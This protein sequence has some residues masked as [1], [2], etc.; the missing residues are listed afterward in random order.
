MGKNRDLVVFALFAAALCGLA[1]LRGPDASCD[2]RNYHIYNAYAVLNHRFGYDLFPAQL[3]TFHAPIL[4]VLYESARIAFNAHP[5][6]LSALLALPHAVAAFLA[7]RITLLF[8][9]SSL[10]ARELLAFV[11]VV[12]G[13]SGA[14]GLPTL[15]S[16]ASEMV[17]G[18]YAL[19]AL[20]IVLKDLG[21][22]HG[23]RKTIS[24]GLLLG[25]AAGFKLTAVPY[26]IGVIAA[27]TLCS[28]RTFPERVTGTLIF[29]GAFLLGAA[30][31]AGPWWL[32]L[33]REYGNPLFPYFN[34]LFRSSLLHPVNISDGRFRPS[35]VLQALLYPFFWA[36]NPKTYVAELPIRDARFA[37]AYTTVAACALQQII[38]WRCARFASELGSRSP[39]SL[40]R[41]LKTEP[42][43]LDNFD[44]KSSCAEA[45]WLEAESPESLHRALN[46]A[47][48]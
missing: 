34:A 4:D 9:P 35:G 11:T 45:R 14:A 32:G 42:P 44:L 20:L 29:V 22:R 18:C 3:Q 8:V 24:A 7:Y 13:A 31:I 26:C 27:W 23:W 28:P 2:L 6:A 33:Y 30:L 19:A 39:D 38:G 25:I 10:P 16:P 12:I 5:K 41:A 15:A 43:E 36:L 21:S 40:N 46:T 37:L 17:P 1:I 47:T 48:P